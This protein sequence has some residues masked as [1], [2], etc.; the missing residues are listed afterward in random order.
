MKHEIRN[1]KYIRHN[2]VTD[3]PCSLFPVPFCL[4]FTIIETLVAIAVLALA[5]T[6]PMVLA[7]R[8][9]V[10]SRAAG[11]EVTAF[12]LAQEAFE[13]VKNVRDANVLAGGGGDSWLSGLKDCTK[14]QA[15][16]IDATAKK[17]SDQIFKCDEEKNNNCTLSKSVQDGLYGYPE[18]HGKGKGDSGWA[19]TSFRRTASVTEVADDTPEVSVS[20]FVSWNDGAG[21]QRSVTIGG[22]M[23]R[24]YSP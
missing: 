10:A 2:K 17:Q 15:C 1:M 14:E 19:E 20:V 6:G 22:N 4:G 24:W 9:L 8:G 13:F 16:G 5:I 7:E 21:R 23:L 18:S 12:Y 11:Q 3:V